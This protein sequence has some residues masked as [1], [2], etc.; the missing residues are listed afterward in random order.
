MRANIKHIR[1]INRIYDYDYV[2]NI[3]G[4]RIPLN[5]SL[6]GYSLEFERKLIREHILYESFIDSLKQAAGIVG[7]SIQQAAQAG[8]EKSKQLVQAAVEQAKNVGE[9][10]KNLAAALTGIFTDSGL[11][12]G[13]LAVLRKKVNTTLEPIEKLLTNIRKIFDKKEL[14]TKYPAIK[15]ILDK[16]K[17]TFDAANNFFL[18]FVKTPLAS[19][20]GWAGALTGASIFVIVYWVLSK[21]KNSILQEAS[22]A[23]EK[24]IGNPAENLQTKLVETLQEIFSGTIK[25]LANKA[26]DNVI[27]SS[28]KAGFTAF[29]PW[30]SAIGNVVGG[31]SFVVSTLS[32]ITDE[33]ANRVKSGKLPGIV[34][35]RQIKATGQSATAFGQAAPA[36]A[37]APAPALP[38]PIAEHAD[39]RTLLEYLER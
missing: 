26:F 35:A 39:L 12:E 5:E 15:T 10:V 2:Q 33:Y 29:A 16:F 20:T 19:L 13:F 37:P 25:Y 1:N 28:L 32:P 17:S 18:N 6:I 36:P 4:I 23:I 11:L 30:L 38:R 22:N 21:T 7:A 8:V 14:L 9:N 34:L 24:F 27:G 3:L 31:V